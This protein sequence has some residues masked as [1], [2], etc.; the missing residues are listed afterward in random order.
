MS[1]LLPRCLTASTISIVILTGVTT[2]QAATIT[3]NGTGY[4]K[5]DDGVCTLAE[6]IDAVNDDVA[7]GALAGECVAGGSEDTIEFDLA[8]PAVIEQPF[9]LTVERSVVIDGPGMDLLT[10]M[11]NNIDRILRITNLVLS[12]FT[13]RGL[14]FSAGFANDNLLGY[15]PSGGAV[16][17]DAQVSP[18]TSEDV[19]ASLMTSRA[20]RNR[21]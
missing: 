11:G 2:L 21:L 20:P 6:A 16:F 3:V 1:F 8:F 9:M 5:A 18:V 12:D 17:V 14:T 19:I 7:S 10:V 15:Q 4:D 13:V